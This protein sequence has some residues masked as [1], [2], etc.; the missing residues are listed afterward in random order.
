MRPSYKI[1]QT[2]IFP[3]GYITHDKITVRILKIG[4]V[5]DHWYDREKKMECGFLRKV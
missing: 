3:I 1:K 2:K 4:D 5:M